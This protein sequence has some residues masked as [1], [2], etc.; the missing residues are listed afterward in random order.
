MKQ[1]NIPAIL[2]FFR[3]NS[4]VVEHSAD[5]TTWVQIPFVCTTPGTATIV[6]AA[7]VSGTW[8]TLLNVA[9][10]IGRLNTVQLIESTADNSNLE[11]KITID[12]GS[13]VTVNVA[14]SSET[15]GLHGV[16]NTK[17][18]SYVGPV[19][20]VT[21][22]LVEVRQTSGGALTIHGSAAYAVV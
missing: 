4:G 22:C 19:E 10:G 14:A 3:H 2:G 15:A 17:T 11:I 20:F 18:I 9:S 5:Y 7:A 13:P 1:L 12:G 21:S 16:G 8:Y 6:Q